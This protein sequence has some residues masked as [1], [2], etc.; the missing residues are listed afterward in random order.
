MGPAATSRLG[1][2]AR[3]TRGSRIGILSLIVSRG[4]HKERALSHWKSRNMRERRGDF[5]DEFR[6]GVES[7]NRCV[8]SF[9]ASLRWILL[10]NGD[11]VLGRNFGHYEIY[12]RAKMWDV[13]WDWRCDW[14]SSEYREK[15]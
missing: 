3:T 1:V 5:G 14:S 10:H 11:D 13:Y 7:T 2:L 15:L 12:V 4:K 9:G 8:I 6:M